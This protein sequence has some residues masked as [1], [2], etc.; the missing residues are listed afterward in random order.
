MSATALPERASVVIVGGGMAGLATAWQ[1]TELGV[2]DVVLLEAEPWLASHASARN[3]AIFL[4]L[5]ESLSA[6]W[7]ASRSRDLIDARIGT[8]WLSAQGVALVAARRDPLD[9]LKFAARQ[10]GVY[11]Q[12]WSPR[13]LARELSYL[14][15]GEC[16][17]GLYLPLGGVMDVHMVLTRMAS[18]IRARGVRV[19]VNTRV[20]SL[21][22]KRG[23]MLGVKLEDGRTLS[24]DRVVLASGA[25][26][27]QLGQA[28]GSHLTLTPFRRHLAQLVGGHMPERRSPVVW[29][30][31]EA[32]YFRPEAGGVLASPCD[33]VS[34]EACEPPSD[35][36]ALHGLAERL[37]RLAPRIAAGA[38]VKRT[39][40]CLRTFT[41]DRELAVGPDAQVKGLY[42][43]AGLG[44]RG[45]TCGVAAGELIARALVGLAHPLTRALTPE[46]FS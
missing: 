3:A 26:A 29:R 34:F 6:V 17:E 44:G 42:W 18:W 32:V 39:W 22:V 27:G 8:S 30:L 20:R 19:A 37:G 21:L 45:M 33:E 10:L 14:G 2:T 46:R 1:L 43:C 4:P 16:R 11:H 31:D 24:A 15:P 38:A 9:A 28:A 13:E 12:C 35:P 41:E 5:E 40:A 25:W 7:L 23:R 36:D